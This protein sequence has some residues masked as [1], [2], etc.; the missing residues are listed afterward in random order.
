[1]A[2][3]LI[4]LPLRPSM[5]DP[6]AGEIK[7]GTAFRRALIPARVSLFAPARWKPHLPQEW[8]D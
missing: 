8:M 4:R 6:A 1:M 5:S 3:I 7:V 2:L